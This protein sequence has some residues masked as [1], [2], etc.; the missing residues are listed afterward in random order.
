[1]QYRDD[2]MENDPKE[3]KSLFTEYRRKAKALYMRAEMDCDAKQKLV[4]S[5]YRF[6]EFLNCLL[7]QVEDPECEAK[8]KG[9]CFRLEHKLFG[10]MEQMTGHFYDGGWPDF[11]L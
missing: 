7:Y 9:F 3:Y 6:H 11:E 5:I 8:V 10:I 4:D 2:E 1:M